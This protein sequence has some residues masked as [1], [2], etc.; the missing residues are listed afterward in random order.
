[1]ET[2][3]T[4]LLPQPVHLQLRYTDRILCM[5]SCFAEHIG[6]RLASRKFRT[7]LN[8]FGILYNPISIC[9]NLQSLLDGDTYTEADLFEHNGRWNS[10]A[11]HG[12]F[13]GFSKEKVLATVQ[14]ESRKAK[15]ALNSTNR[16]LLTFGTAFVFRYKPTGR[17]VANCHKLAN[18]QFTR[19]RL[20]VDEIVQVWRS[21]LHALKVVLPDVE[22]ILTV[23]PVRHL[24]DG[25]I[26]NQR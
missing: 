11:H 7:S 15:A 4:Q 20:T 25:L 12:R 6:Q 1:M 18:D 2:F 21:L 19:K 16:I 24:R 9:D 13:S 3:R 5:G 10:F 8:P 14:E 26:E 22:L 17:V 23:S